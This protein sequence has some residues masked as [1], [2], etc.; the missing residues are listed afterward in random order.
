MTKRILATT[1]AGTMAACMLAGAAVSVSAEE[2]NDYSI[3]VILKTTAAEYWQYV[4]AGAEQAGEDL[5]VKVDVKG[6]TS[7]TAYDEQQNIIETD[8]S[9]GAYD[10]IIIAPLQA[11]QAATLVK[12]AEMPI[13]AVDTK[14]EA[15]EVVSFIGTGNEAAAALGGKAAVEAAKEAGW[16]EIK[17]IEICGVQGDGTASDRLTGYEEGIDEAGGDFLE[18]ETQYSDAVADKAVTCME[19]I[20][21]NHPE[22]IAIIVGHN[23]DVVM[24]AARAAEGNEAY[25]NTIF[26]GFNGDRAA[27]EAILAGE[28]TMSVIQ[29]AYGMGYKAVQTAVDSLNGEEVE[30]FVDSGSGVVD[31]SSAQE[32]LDTLKTYLD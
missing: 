8:L 21:Q 16:E 32:R 20:M 2:S 24:A 17:A 18:D 22:G 30:S 4:M 5:G 15:D 10:A 19:A 3:D 9:S 31:A 25:A 13:F 29:D 23:D 7:E 14:F 1:L 26:C 11:D 27:C 6:A 28:E 12:D